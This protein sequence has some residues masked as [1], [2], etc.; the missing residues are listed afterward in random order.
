M[1]IIVLILNTLAL[2]NNEVPNFID[3]YQNYKDHVRCRILQKNVVV[4]IRFHK[5]F[6]GYF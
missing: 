6:I 4:S 5:L 2:T 3:K 1:Y